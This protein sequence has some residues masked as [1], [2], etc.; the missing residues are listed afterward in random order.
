M[1]KPY[2]SFNLSAGILDGEITEKNIIDTDRKIETDR[3]H[4]CFIRPEPS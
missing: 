4:C 2:G 3:S 1:D